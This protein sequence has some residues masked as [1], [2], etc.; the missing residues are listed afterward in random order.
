MTTARA[1]VSFAVTSGAST[2]RLKGRLLLRPQRFDGL[3]QLLAE[4][5]AVGKLRQSIV[6]GEPGN[7]VFSSAFFRDVLHE[8]DPAAV[9]QGLIANEDGTAV[10]EVGCVKASGNE[11][12]CPC[13]TTGM[14]LSWVHLTHSASPSSRVVGVSACRIPRD[15]ISGS[16]MEALIGA[17][18]APW[19]V[20][21][22]WRV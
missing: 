20:K 11:N 17:S 1:C 2:V 12:I 16:S 3:L 13:S 4:V 9:G 10:F 22:P 19:I 18:S 15:T 21:W 14:T 6:T 5:K 8:I 7:L